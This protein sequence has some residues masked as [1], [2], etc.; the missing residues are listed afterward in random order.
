MLK[1]KDYQR[2]WHTFDVKMSKSSNK[3]H[4]KYLK[5]KKYL[6]LQNLY[7]FKERRFGCFEI[8]FLFLLQSSVIPISLSEMIKGSWHM[9]PTWTPSLT[10]IS[11]R[12]HFNALGRHET[13]QRF[14]N[15]FLQIGHMSLQVMLM[16]LSSLLLQPCGSLISQRAAASA[17]VSTDE[18][19]A[20][21]CLPPPPTSLPPADTFK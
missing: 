9:L 6:I 4:I 8:I 17:I 5:Y 1:N 14:A 10:S 15:Q 18:G 19:L 16:D 20:T 3:K 12:E 21:P 2:T 11:W 7:H 13:T